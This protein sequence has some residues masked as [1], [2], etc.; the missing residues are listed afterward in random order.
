MASLDDQLSPTTDVV[1]ENPIFECEPDTDKELDVSN[2]AKPSRPNE[3]SDVANSKNSSQNI[4][5]QRKEKFQNFPLMNVMN[6]SDSSISSESERILP[7]VQNSDQN[8]D[9]AEKFE[10]KIAKLNANEK[11]NETGCNAKSSAEVFA[12]N[13]DEKNSKDSLERNIGKSNM[14]M[15]Y[16]NEKNKKLGFEVRSSAEAFA[17]RIEAKNRKDSLERKRLSSSEPNANYKPKIFKSSITTS[18]SSSVQNQPERSLLERYHEQGARPKEKPSDITQFKA[19]IDT[20]NENAA[21][22]T[23]KNIHHGQKNM[24]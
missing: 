17:Q 10:R 11:M 19:S 12:Q 3:S 5:T 24:K 21:S 6:D 7:S 22:K 18:V 14:T 13:F 8:L 4:E 2:R 1:R 23:F 9:A 20:I 16:T 15:K